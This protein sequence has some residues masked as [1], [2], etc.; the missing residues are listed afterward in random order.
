MHESG[1]TEI[2]PVLHV[3]ASWGQYPGLAHPESPQGAP[4]EVAAV[5]E[6]SKWAT[7]LSPP[8]KE[9]VAVATG[10]LV[11]ASFVCKHGRQYF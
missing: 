9:W 2:I 4:L 1:L 7:G 11:V 6:A 3:S 5:V 8:P 10:G